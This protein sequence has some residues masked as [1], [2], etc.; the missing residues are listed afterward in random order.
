[1]EIEPKLTDIYAFGEWLKKNYIGSSRKPIT[2]TPQIGGLITVELAK[3]TNG[4]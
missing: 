4:N 1:M 2:I 3:E